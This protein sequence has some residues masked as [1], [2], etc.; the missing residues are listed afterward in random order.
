MLKLASRRIKNV[1]TILLMVLFVA[2]LTD[3]ATSTQD[4]SSGKVIDIAIQN[5]AS[6]PDSV[7]TSADNTVRWTNMDLA[8][9]TVDGPIFKSGI[10]TKGQNYEFRFTEPGVYN[11]ECSIHPSMK[12]TITVVAKK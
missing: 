6:N 3:L 7:K 5:F 12:G 9:H 2:F 1:L 11:Y 10:I 4:N 8:E